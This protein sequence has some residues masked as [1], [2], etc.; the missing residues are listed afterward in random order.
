MALSQASSPRVNVISERSIYV[1][2]A[3][4][5]PATIPVGLLK[6]VQ[7]GSTQ[8]GEFAYGNKYLQSGE[9]HA[10]NT[11]YLPLQMEV[12]SLEARPLRGGG[13]L[14]LT[15]QDALPDSWGRRVL[16]AR[17]GN[18]LSDIDALLASNGDRIG[19]MQFSGSLPFKPADQS[20]DPVTL[21][22]CAPCKRRR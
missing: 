10:L 6:T 22:Q 4:A 1:G 7:R 5:K 12:F 15:L 17:Y 9:A 13:A 19:A 2:L 18:T 16:E 3:T 21:V 8:S 14:P 20:T 11:L